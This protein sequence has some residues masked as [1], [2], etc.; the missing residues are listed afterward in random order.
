MYISRKGIRL[1]ASCLPPFTVPGCLR[2]GLEESTFKATLFEDDW[3]N[4]GFIGIERA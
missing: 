4:F 1:L 2:L 3:R